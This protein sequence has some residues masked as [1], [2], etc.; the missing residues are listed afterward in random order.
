MFFATFQLLLV[1]FAPRAEIFH[2]RQQFSI[3][4]TFVF[5]FHVLQ[6]L[7]LFHF[8]CQQSCDCYRVVSCWTIWWIFWISGMLSRICSM[9]IENTTNFI[10]F[11]C[12]FVFSI[13]NLWIFSC[14]KFW[15]LVGVNMLSRMFNLCNI[16]MCSKHQQHLIIITH[17]LNSINLHFVNFGYNLI[18]FHLLILIPFCVLCKC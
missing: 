15:I 17:L 6:I 16:K 7:S 4:L 1:R 11:D 13:S 8:V 5:V 3:F 10:I 12:S 18:S 9:L 14:M 2:P